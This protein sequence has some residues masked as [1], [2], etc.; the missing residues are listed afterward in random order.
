MIKSKQLSPLEKARLAKAKNKGKPARKATYPT[1][2]AP[3]DFKSHV[4]EI[5]V[6]TD[7]DGLLAPVIRLTRYRGQFDPNADPRKKW[8]VNEYDMPTCMGVLSRLSMVTFVNSMAKR[9]P[10]NT[11]FR[12]VIRVGM[13]KA[14]GN[15]LTCSFKQ[16]DQIDR[17]PNGK[18]KITPL[19][20]K[21][22]IYRKFRK[23]GRLLPAA[24]VNVL[25]PPKRTRQKKAEE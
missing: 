22:P 19:D 23:A 17:K 16:I 20:K 14:R 4:L 18:A 10:A 24:F 2:K 6:K 13:S 12:I 5:L 9:L 7:K 25:M 15:V 11:K 1:W 3:V 8:V 21:D